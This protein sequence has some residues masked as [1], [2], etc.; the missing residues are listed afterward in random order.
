MRCHIDNKLVFSTTYKG[1]KLNVHAGGLIRDFDPFRY[2]VVITA[3]DLGFPFC[4]FDPDLFENQLNVVYIPIYDG[5]A[6]GIQL[7]MW[8]NII[9]SIVRNIKKDTINI[10][11]C[12][13][14]GHGRTGVILAVLMFL[15]TNVKDIIEY[16]RKNY[17]E[18]A[19]ETYSQMLYLM[20]CGIDTKNYE[21]SIERD[22]RGYYTEADDYKI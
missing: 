2:D 1:K 8:L 4:N 5:E 12:C 7:E 19:I 18:K 11:V 15:L 9:D 17:C 10:G 14:G 13:A 3:E 16:I 6:P 22:I 20:E 21:P